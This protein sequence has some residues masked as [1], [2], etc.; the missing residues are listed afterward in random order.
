M[1][2]VIH[3]FGSALHS[4]SLKSLPVPTLL[5]IHKFLLS[6]KLRTFSSKTAQDEMLDVRTIVPSSVLT[7]SES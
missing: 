3:F 5:E 7:N 1:N 2:G 6:D 4:L